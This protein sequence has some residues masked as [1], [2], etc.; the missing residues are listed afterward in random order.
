M[1]LNW[2]RGLGE[3]LGLVSSNG[4]SVPV[5][6]SP[7]CDLPAEPCR[8]TQQLTPVELDNIKLEAEAL[9]AEAQL[10]QAMASHQE[11]I[12]EATPE[13]KK[14]TSQLREMNE[15]AAGEQPAQT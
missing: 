11:T 2:L 14:I 10:Q 8:R 5:A 13:L 15:Q 6:A 7:V 4:H 3:R 12:T 1:M 9:E